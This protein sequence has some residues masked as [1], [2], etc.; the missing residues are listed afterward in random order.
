MS[1]P[2]VV[3]QDVEPPLLAVDPLD[4]GAGPV[5]V[6][7]VSGDSDAGAAG[8]RG[9]LRGLLDG[10]RGPADLTGVPAGG[11]AGDIDGGACATEFDGESTSGARG[12]P[13]TSAIR[14]ASARPALRRPGTDGRSAAV[15]QGRPERLPALHLEKAHGA[16]A[17]GK[18]VP[19]TCLGRP[20]GPTEPA[21]PGRRS[22]AVETDAGRDAGAAGLLVPGGRSVLVSFWWYSSPLLSDEQVLLRRCPSPGQ[23]TMTAFLAGPVAASAWAD[24]MEPIAVGVIH[25]ARRSCGVRPG[26]ARHLRRS[27]SPCA[28]L[29]VRKPD[30]AMS[31]V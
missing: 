21:A 26:A 6:Q 15:G 3:D 16:R 7:V 14:P 18:V 10:L 29:L 28:G 23:L 20:A 9:Q 11:A 5:R 4:E 1:A 27:V 12:A 24:G 2:E 30:R 8:R 13:A 25:S 31:S 19:A 22:R 17:V